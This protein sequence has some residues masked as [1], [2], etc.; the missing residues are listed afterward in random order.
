MGAIALEVAGT[1]RA[2]GA[3]N[4]DAYLIAAEQLLFGVFDG[5]GATTQAA[6]AAE[7][8]A[9][10]I[11][12]AYRQH[13]SDDGEDERA[14][15]LEAVR[16]AGAAI[17][18]ELDDGLTTASVVKVGPRD[19][20]GATAVIANIGDSRIYRYTSGNDLEQCTLDDSLF[21]ADWDLQWRLS[22]VVAPVTLL[23]VMYLQQRN[24][25]DRCLGAPGDTARVWETGLEDGDVLLA[26]TDG[27]TDNL[28]ASEVRALVHESAGSPERTAQRLV[29]AAVARS[30]A[31][32]HARAKVDDITAVVARVHVTT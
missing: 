9:A 17:E 16:A 20:G 28:T 30:R 23:E 7:L 24:I 4:E 8:A 31:T 10:T 27:V 2:K 3:V 29:E 21:G 6:Q 5:V 26:L 15:L 25:L 1:T 14:F 18:A 22:E 32:D 13:H 19:D 12:A 11:R